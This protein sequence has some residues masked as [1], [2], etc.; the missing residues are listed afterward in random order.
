MTVQGPTQLSISLG[1][2]LS[3]PTGVE[4]SFCSLEYLSQA[5]HVVSQFFGMH[6]PLSGVLSPGHQQPLLTNI[7]WHQ[8]L[9]RV[10]LWWGAK[11]Q[12]YSCVQLTDKQMHVWI[13]VLLML[14]VIDGLNCVVSVWLKHSTKP[15]IWECWGG[16]YF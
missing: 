5:E 16:V 1:G 11:C 2:E 4:H 8:L 12:V 3:F 13:P 10:G 15:L 6:Q 9:H 7:P 14:D